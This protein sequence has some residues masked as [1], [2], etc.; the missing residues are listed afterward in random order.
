M[1]Y[2]GAHNKPAIENFIKTCEMY[3][4]NKNK[5]YII[6]ILKTKDYKMILEKLL[7]DEKSM[8]I[9]TDGNNKDRYVSKEE[10]LETAKKYAKNKNLYV[11]ELENAIDYVK[12]K[13]VNDII[14]FVGSFYIYGTVIKKL[15]EDKND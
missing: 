7:K 9:F 12:E 1:I 2:D 14:F 3:Y 6:S 5:V 13:H 4:K 8:F 11:K 15:K 10:L